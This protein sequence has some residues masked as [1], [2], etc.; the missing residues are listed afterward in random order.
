[1][2]CRRLSYLVAFL[3]VSAFVAQTLVQAKEVPS[4]VAVNPVPQNKDWW[5]QRQEK[6]NARVKQG[7]VQ[8]LFI[9]DSITHGWESRGKNVWKKY[10]G[11]RHAVNLGFSGDQTQNVLWRFDHGNL[12]GI[13]PKLAVV[14]IGTNNAGY[15]QPE[16]TAEGVKA[17]VDELRAKLPET[18]ILLLAIFPRG[19]DA[20]DWARQIN[21]KTDKIIAKLAD[22]KMVFYLDIGPKF[23]NADGTLSKDIMRDLLHPTAQ[24][25]E[26]WAAAIEPTVAKLMGDKQKE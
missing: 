1:M 15:K 16:G 19:A 25:Y 4:N 24:G 22:G 14:M 3:T 17:I 7:D 20:N 26:I 12:D 9:G 21:E 8:L 11:D 13:S 23:L 2:K 6:V 18:K 5:K 10:Y